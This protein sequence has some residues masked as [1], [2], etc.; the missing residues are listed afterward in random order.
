MDRTETQR[1]I[2]EILAR[3][4]RLR[5]WPDT[6]EGLIAEIMTVHD[7]AVEA[8]LSEYDETMNDGAGQALARVLRSK[9]RGMPDHP[10]IP[11]GQFA[12]GEIMRALERVEGH[13]AL[14]DLENVDLEPVDE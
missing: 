5:D 1:R 2:E 14:E 11:G 10:W 9:I 13:S 7:E 12:D 8:A 4:P 3:S 6:R